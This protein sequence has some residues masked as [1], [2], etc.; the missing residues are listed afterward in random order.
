MSE[1]DMKLSVRKI[2]AANSPFLFYTCK[3]ENQ[4][5]IYSQFNGNTAYMLEDNDLSTEGN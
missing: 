2:C 4:E 3:L 1:M 5:W